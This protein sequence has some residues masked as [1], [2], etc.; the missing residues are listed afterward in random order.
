MDLFSSIAFL[1]QSFE[2][3]DLGVVFFLVL[4]EGLLS[5][6]NAL[7][8]AIMVKHL[9]AAQQKKALVYGLAGAFVFRFVAILLASTIISLWWLQLIG[10]GYL[11]FVCAKHFLTLG[12]ESKKSLKAGAG[13]WQTVVAVEL[14][15]IAFAVDSVIAAVALVKGTDKLWVVY[16]GAVL[17]VVLLRFAAGFFINLL[18]KYPSLDHM[19]YTLV[20][21]VG[22]KLLFMAGHHATHL[23]NETHF[24]RITEI[25][26][27]DIKVFWGVMGL[28]VLAGSFY[29]WKKGSGRTPALAMEEQAG[30]AVEE[31]FHEMTDV[32]S[33][34]GAK[35]PDFSPDPARAKTE[36]PKD[37]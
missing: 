27:M 22:V 29:A 16:L 19:A 12:K 9:P 34:P 31:A 30:Q 37:E 28:L 25:P 10:A 21:W 4:L 5:A 15:D 32:P 7:V 26:E 8:L 18:E 6:D 35:G 2:T 20:G 33:E 13:F 14:T 11:V 23:Y 24:P 36:Q 1:G 17:G 3:S